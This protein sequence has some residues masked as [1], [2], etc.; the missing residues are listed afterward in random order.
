M[1]WLLRG[2]YFETCN[3]ETACPCVWLQSPTDGD[4]KLL[5]AWHIEHGHL[6]EHILDGLNVA[7]A[8]YAPADMKDG[9][10]QA[11]LY[12]DERA[13]EAQF[14]AIVQIFSGQ[15]GGH[16][17]VLMSFVSEV[18]GVKKVK[19]DYQEQGNKRSMLIPDIAQADIESIQGLTGEQP[20]ISNPPLCVV[21]SHPSIV[22]KS[23]N[24]Q[25]QDYGK[26]WQFSD[27]NGYFSDFVYQP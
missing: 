20:T 9:N 13:D 11:A 15:Q 3:C 4:C 14:N 17:A 12:V 1:N 19:I 21:T 8:C 26:N 7:M 24:Y 22:A 10:W 16:L 25:Y 5:V 18:L 6:D 27:K 2:S 23:K